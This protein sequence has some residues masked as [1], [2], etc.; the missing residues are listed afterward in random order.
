MAESSTQ[1]IHKEN[2]NKILHML[3]RLE[4]LIDSTT[5]HSWDDKSC[6]VQFNEKELEQLIKKTIE[7]TV[8]LIDDDE[9]EDAA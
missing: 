8:S 3:W 6:E 1:T 4:T 5:G 7:F 2:L 9:S